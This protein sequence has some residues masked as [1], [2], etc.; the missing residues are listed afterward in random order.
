MRPSRREGGIQGKVD[1]IDYLTIRIKVLEE[2]INHVRASVDKRSAMSYGFA[3]WERIE[4]AHAVARAALHKH[5]QG[6][7]IKLAPRPSDIIWENLHL[8]SPLR[9]WRRFMNLIYVI[10]LTVLWIAPNALIAVFLSNLNNLG[11]VWPTF[12]TSLNAEPRVWAAVQGILAPAITSLVYLVLPIIF[13]RLAVRAGNLT[14][15]AREKDVM[16]RLYA[17]FVFNNLIVFSM[18]S[19]AWTFVSTVVNATHHNHSAWDAIRSSNVA[20]KIFGSLCQVSPF[21]VAWLLQRSFGAA[22]DLAQLSN[23]IRV[24]FSKVF[25]APT[26]RQTIEWTAPPPFDYATYYNYFLF[27]ITVALCFATLQPIVLPVT[28]FYFGLDTVMKKYLLMYVFV[29]K[30]E[31]GGRFWRLI[32]NRM[33]FATILANCV[34]ALAVIAKGTWTMVYCLIPLPFLMIGLKVYCK[35]MFDADMDF[36]NRGQLS[37]EEALDDT[38]KASSLSSLTSKASEGLSA[39]FGHPALYKPLITP[40]VHA[41]A[42]DALRKVYQGRLDPTDYTGEYSDIMLD[43]MTSGQPGRK[44]MGPF[45]GNNNNNNTTAPFEFVPESH[46]DF[47]YFKDRPEFRDEL[48]GGIYG[49]PDD[50]IMGMGIERSHRRFMTS[51][52]AGSNENASL[53]STR[54]PS[55]TYD[56][57]GEDVADMRAL[58]DEQHRG[59]YDHSNESETRLLDNAEQPARSVPPV[60]VAGAGTAT[61]TATETGA[62]AYGY[63]R[64]QQEDEEFVEL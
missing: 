40:M 15:T 51:T 43:H 44:S 18:F 29:T 21:W 22:I 47:A 42:G 52:T 62:G 58:Y 20:A 35:K 41:K 30:N 23:M 36:Y 60:S 53:S 9:R 7:N 64:V 12:Q 34:V 6:T 28:A 5:P 50:S 8:S 27:Y 11:R 57:T 19:A 55:P 16:D 63:G 39:K 13:R 49:R 24:S 48:G 3:S 4:H 56:Y 26:P 46:L 25:M 31:S 54:P 1:A 59:L 45:A 38:G 61:G 33:V 37:D 32:F 14:K 2:E 17:F 10:A